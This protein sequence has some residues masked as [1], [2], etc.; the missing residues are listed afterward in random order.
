MEKPEKWETCLNVLKYEPDRTL[1]T[2]KCPGSHKRKGELV[3]DKQKCEGCLQWR[4]WREKTEKE[5]LK[6][7]AGTANT[8]AKCKAQTAQ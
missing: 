2:H 8:P 7:T 4:G 1:L 6:I 3:L 5:I